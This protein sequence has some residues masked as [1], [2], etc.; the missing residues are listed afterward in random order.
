VAYV[1]LGKAVDKEAFTAFLRDRLSPVKV[2]VR[3]F[4]VNSFPLTANGKLQRA[5]LAPESEKF[6]VREIT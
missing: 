3:F 6:V 5:L 1:E 4:E 2:P